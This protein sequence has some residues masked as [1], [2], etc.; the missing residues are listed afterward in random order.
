[1]PVDTLPPGCLISWC[2]FLDVALLR[3]TPKLP[4]PLALRRTAP[5]A[6]EYP[7]VTRSCFLAGGLC[8][9]GLQKMLP[10]LRV[11]IVYLPPLS[12]TLLPSEIAP[13]VS[14]DHDC[15][16]Q[17]APYSVFSTMLNMKIW[18]SHIICPFSRSRLLLKPSSISCRELIIKMLILC[19]LF[20]F[21]IASNLAEGTRS[22]RASERFKF[23]HKL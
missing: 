4:P 9:S 14:S 11:H 18:S 17:S 5:V 10:G 8:V 19:I 7:P 22:A 16:F 20:G 13:R 23:L 2:A 15:G 3:V 6:S 21:L 1:M 12:R